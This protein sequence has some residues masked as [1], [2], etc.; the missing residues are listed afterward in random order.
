MNRFTTA[1]LALALSACAAP[2]TAAAQAPGALKDGIVGAWSLA[3]IY[4]EDDFGEDLDRWGSAPRGHLS[5]DASGRFMLQIA[6]R[7][8]IRLASADA[9]TN[10]VPT[11]GN[12]RA[13]VAYAGVYALDRA[14]GTIV[15]TI[16]DAVSAEA[17]AQA[18]AAVNIDAD[19]TL[20]F[21]SSAESSPTGAFYSHTAWKRAGSRAK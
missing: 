12:G 4:E 9:A 5:V 2:L 16:E 6:A 11:C 17:G 3:S 8:P 20:H 19:G 13:C 18:T 7:E 21:V 10:T 14:R 1:L 15:F